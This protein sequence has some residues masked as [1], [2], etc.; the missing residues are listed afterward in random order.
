MKLDFD[1][2]PVEYCYNC[3]RPCMPKTADYCISDALINSV[4]RNVKDGLVF[5]GSNAYRIDK[6]TNVKDLVSQLITEAK[7]NYEL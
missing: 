2:I 7:K 6:I 3:L 4:K 1:K 5:A